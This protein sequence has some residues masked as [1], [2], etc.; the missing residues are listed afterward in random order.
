MSRLHCIALQLFEEFDNFHKTLLDAMGK[1]DG[2]SLELMGLTTNRLSLWT[3]IQLAIAVCESE[4]DCT[5][6]Q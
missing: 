2:V 1:Q 4:T 6:K 3:T 5:L